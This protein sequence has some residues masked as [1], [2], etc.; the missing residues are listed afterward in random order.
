MAQWLLFAW[1]FCR[2]NFF[3]IWIYV[4]VK[5]VAF[6]E[7]CKPPKASESEPRLSSGCPQFLDTP[8]QQ[9]SICRVIASPTADNSP[10]MIYPQQATVDD[11]DD[12]SGMAMEHSNPP[13][14]W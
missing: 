6:F 3:R 7:F 5:L 12:G 10:V 14:S 9:F 11:A 4:L 1:I 13:L 2:R 8:F